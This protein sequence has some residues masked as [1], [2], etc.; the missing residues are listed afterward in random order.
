[1]GYVFKDEQGN[2][3]V[4]RPSATAGIAKGDP[5]KRARAY[6]DTSLIVGLAKRDLRPTEHE[7]LR[8]LLRLGKAGRI[9]LVTSSVTEEEISR[10]AGELR[11]L[12]EDIYALLS[13]VPTV[14]E[15]RTD[16][17]M[18]LM[19]VGGGVRDD[20]AFAAMKELLP[21]VDD[22]RHVFQAL[23]NGVDYFVTDDWRTI[24]SRASE[25]EA[26]VSIHVRLPSEL[27]TELSDGDS[28]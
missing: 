15:S 27:V 28:P 2:V 12:Q 13:D 7:A 6:L 19:G 22:A 17:G 9:E 23:V 4:H 21:G 11:E 1:M 14:P 8:E 24:V 26:Q 10:Y 25:I 18:L 20:P 16:S 5:A 3:T